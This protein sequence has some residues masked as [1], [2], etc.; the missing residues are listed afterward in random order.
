MPGQYW[1][2]ND[3]VTRKI[4][5]NIQNKVITFVTTYRITEYDCMCNFYIFCCL[6]DDS[7]TKNS[8][9]YL[10]MTE[11]FIPYKSC[12]V[13]LKY[14]LYLSVCFLS[15]RLNWCLLLGL[16]ITKIYLLPENFS[17]LLCYNYTPLDTHKVVCERKV[18]TINFVCM[19]I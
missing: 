16:S 5:N 2:N 1:E 7:K 13:Y 14:H 11:I 17:L 15:K 9:L 10:L 8:N 18:L 19:F 6:S 3:N 12:L 4:P